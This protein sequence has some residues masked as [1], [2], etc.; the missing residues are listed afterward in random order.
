MA[1]NDRMPMVFVEATLNSERYIQNIVQSILLP[2]LQRQG[3]VLFQQDNVRTHTSRVTQCTLEDSSS[4]VGMGDWYGWLVLFVGFAQYSS[5]FGRNWSRQKSDLGGVISVELVSGGVSLEWRQSWVESQHRGLERGHR[6]PKIPEKTRRPVALSSTILTCKNP[7]VTRSESNPVHLAYQSFPSDKCV[8]VFTRSNNLYRHKKKCKGIV[9]LSS[10]SEC[11]CCT[12]KI[13]IDNLKIET[14]HLSLV[15][16]PIHVLTTRAGEVPSGPVLDRHC[17][18]RRINAIIAYVYTRLHEPAR[19]LAMSLCTH[20]ICEP[21]SVTKSLQDARIQATHTH[22]Y[23][24]HDAS[25][26]CSNDP[27]M[28]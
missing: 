21:S 11:K 23:N 12:K 10:G 26:L 1:Y 27:L 22:T 16:R 14:V 8:T 2:F 17:A 28:N 19:L 13:A 4:S 18:V 24:V 5:Q 7:G 9:C 3:D 25:S 15:I 20:Q 6:K